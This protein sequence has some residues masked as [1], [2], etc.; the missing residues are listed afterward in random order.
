MSYMH[1]KILG[2]CSKMAVERNHRV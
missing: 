1:S 2:L